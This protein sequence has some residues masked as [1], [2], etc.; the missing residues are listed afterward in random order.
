M[1]LYWLVLSFAL[2]LSPHSQPLLRHGVL[3]TAV[4]QVLLEEGALFA[5]DKGLRRSAALMI[6]VAFR[7]S[8]LDL[9]AVGDKGRSFCAFQ[10]H[11]SSGGSPAL[12]E[13][14]LA[15]ARK[16][17]EMLKRSITV[18]RAHPIASY[19]RGPRWATVEA[20]RISNDRMALA[21][22]LASLP[23]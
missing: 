15:C 13:N 18:D 2:A 8:S 12:L 11:E 9:R 6:A 3:A 1:T 10:I 19:A 7:E 21:K 16:A 22:R 14:P 20:Q 5:N 17:H 4:A 23:E